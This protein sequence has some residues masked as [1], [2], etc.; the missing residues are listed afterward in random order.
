[1]ESHERTSGRSAQ[2]EALRIKQSLPELPR[3]HKEPQTNHHASGDGASLRD[4]GT[5]RLDLD[6]RWPKDQMGRQEGKDH[7]RQGSDQT[8]HARLSQAMALGVIAAVTSP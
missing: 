8:T 5:P 7:R 2:S 3:L 4:S 1:M 6:A